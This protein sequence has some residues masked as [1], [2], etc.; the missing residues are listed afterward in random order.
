MRR[1]AF[2]IEAITRLEKVA[3]ALIQ[4]NFE[5]TAQHVEEFLA[6][7]GIRFATTTAGLYAEKMRL[8]RGVAPGEQF[9]ANAG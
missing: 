4:A 9:H 2:E 5:F 8:H 7:M 6:L 1:G 3:F